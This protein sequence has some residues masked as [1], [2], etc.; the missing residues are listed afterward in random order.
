MIRKVDGLVAPARPGFAVPIAC[1]KLVAARCHAG[2]IGTHDYEVRRIARCGCSLAYTVEGCLQVLRVTDLL[3]E[4]LEVIAEQGAFA[5]AV[6]GIPRITL[7]S[8][9][10]LEAALRPIVDAVRAR[11]YLRE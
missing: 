10:L 3:L 6:S 8:Q 1:A 5:A 2:P 4:I 7:T 11:F 9:E